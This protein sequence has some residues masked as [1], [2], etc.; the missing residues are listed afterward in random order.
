MRHEQRVFGC[1]V[2][3]G[4]VS[5]PVG[6]PVSETRVHDLAARCDDPWRSE[7]GGHRRAVPWL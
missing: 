3:R 6:P 1:V 7:R 5:K 2:Q 4:R